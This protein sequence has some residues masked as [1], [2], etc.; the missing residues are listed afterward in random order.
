M[1][2]KPLGRL[3]TTPFKHRQFRLP[4]KQKTLVNLA[5]LLILIPIVMMIITPYLWMLTASL[6]ERGSIGEP[7]YLY[8]TT[9]DFTNYQ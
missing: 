8:P 5:L 4:G 2:T 7:P 6:K 3:A 9:F 1:Q